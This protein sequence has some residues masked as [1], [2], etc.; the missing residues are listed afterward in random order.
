MTVRDGSDDAVQGRGAMTW[1]RSLAFFRSSLRRQQTSG[2]LSYLR[3]LFARI[4]NRYVLSGGEAN[5]DRVGFS[6]THL[7]E[8]LMTRQQVLLAILAASQGRPY[9]PVQIQKAAFLVT[10]NLPSLVDEGSNFSFDPYDY[11]PFDQAVYAEAE[12]L[13]SV[14]AV[15]I[16][17]QDGVRWSRYAASDQGV[18]T[19]TDLLSRMA[20]RDRE[21]IET[22]SKWVRG[23]SFDSLVKSIYA[24]YP[25]MKA[26]SIF[27]G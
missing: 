5:R 9:T 4:V 12:R 16:V 7:G 18:Q 24:Q 6:G 10:R 21:Y 19:G 8:N 20:P 27:R 14:G 23:Q 13:G 15:E 22:V 25:E 2:R 1:L 17:P 26:N 3:A 11:G